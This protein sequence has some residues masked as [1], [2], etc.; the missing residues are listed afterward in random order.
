MEVP[1]NKQKTTK[2][3]SLPN[4]VL[5]ECF[6]YLNSFD[7][8]SSFTQLNDRCERLAG[9]I[10]LHLNFENIDQAMFE[11]FRTIIFSN[12]AP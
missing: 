12:E 5:I 8:F 7:L 9:S 11:R 2:F 4:E 10:P 6:E 1:V 3:E